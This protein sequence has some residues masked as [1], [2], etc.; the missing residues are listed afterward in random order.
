M[1]ILGKSPVVVGVTVPKGGAAEQ[2]TPPGSKP[3]SPASQADGD[4]GYLNQPVNKTAAFFDAYASAKGFIKNGRIGAADL[5][6]L[7]P[8]G[9]PNSFI[10]SGTIAD[11]SKFQYKWNGQKV[12][13][14]WHAPDANAAAKFPGSNAGSGWTAQIKIGNKLLGQDGLLYRQPSNT[15]HIPV[16]F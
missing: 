5:E 12:E 7:V 1:E 4:F 3:G 11:G 15:T 14:K 10:P 16:D 9:T 13:I 8:P 2:A 6:K